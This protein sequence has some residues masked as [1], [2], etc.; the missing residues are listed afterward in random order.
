METEKLIEM[1]KDVAKNAY[2]PYS[3]FHIG[4]A[5]L[6]KS[7]KIFTGCNVENASYSMTICAERNA[8]FNAVANGEKEL[9]KIVIYADTDVFFPPCGACRQ[10]MAEFASDMEIIIVNQDKIV[11]TSLSELLPFKFE[12]ENEK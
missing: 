9:S 5:L 6:T 8:I 12:L 7:G 1:A 3:G 4:A 11:E 2:V 10:V